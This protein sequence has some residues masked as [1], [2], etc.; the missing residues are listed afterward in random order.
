M[1]SCDSEPVPIEPKSY[2]PGL[3]LIR[4]SNCRHAGHAE[5]AIDCQHARLRHQ[6]GDQCEILSRIIRKFAE[7]QRV[8]GKRAADA[9]ADGRAVRRGFGHGVGAD[10]A[11]RARP[12]LDDERSGRSLLMQVIGD[13]AG[14]EIG[15]CP[16][17]RMAR[18]ILRSFLANPAP[19]QGGR[20]G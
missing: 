15:R 1:A 6:H 10:I 5:T 7:Q 18:L 19:R 9:D 11:A 16:G 4:S 2:L 13:Q 20:A 17:R 3:R 12:V 8:D 14:D